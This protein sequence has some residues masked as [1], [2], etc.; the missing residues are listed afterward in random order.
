MRC[1]NTSMS[2]S[3]VVKA[4]CAEE[5]KHE[6]VELAAQSIKSTEF[7]KNKKLP[8]CASIDPLK[9]RIFPDLSAQQL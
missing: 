8:Q 4:L 3:V 5:M 2:R 1:Q 7:R 9:Q 6:N